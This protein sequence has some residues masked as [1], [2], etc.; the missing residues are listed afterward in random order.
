MIRDH[1]RAG[2]VEGAEFTGDEEHAPRLVLLTEPS[3]LGVLPESK[4]L[5]EDEQGRQGCQ[6]KHYIWFWNR[7]KGFK[8]CSNGQPP[9]VTNSNFSRKPL[10]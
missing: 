10:T 2:S 7:Q 9:R 4:L 6:A 3:D 1:G 8:D 5:V